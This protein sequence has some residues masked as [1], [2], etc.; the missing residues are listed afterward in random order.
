MLAKRGFQVKVFERRPDVRKAK[1][2][3]VAG[4][5]DA[6]HGQLTDSSKRSINLALSHRGLCGLDKAGLKERVLEWCIPMKG[7]VLHDNSGNIVLQP[8]DANHQAIYS[9]SRNDLNWLLIEEAEKYPNVEFLF[10]YKFIRVD[11]DGM[12]LFQRINADGSSLGPSG[13][14]EVR[15]SV[16]LGADGAF[17][18]V[19]K[20]LARLTRQSTSMEYIKHGYK[21]LHIP[22]TDSGDFAMESEGLHIWPRRE[23]MMIGLPNPDKSFTCTLFA[24]FEG[25]GGFDSL[26][27]REQVEAYFKKYFADAIPLMPN[28]LD[29]FFNNPTSALL[30]LKCSPWNFKDKVAVIGDAAHAIVPFYGQGMNAC[31]EDCVIMDELLETY[32]NDW[33]KVLPAFSATRAPSTNGLAELSLDNYV[34][35]RERTASRLIRAKRAVERAIHTI[36]PSFVPLYTMVA[37]T[38]TP[39]HQAIEKARKQDK[40]LNWVLASSAISV[41]AGASYGLMRYFGYK[42][43]NVNFS[44]SLKK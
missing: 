43:V 11:R 44:V 39:Y 7:R 18:A 35:M 38:R 34:E 3:A 14:L 9:V 23:F 2:A 15:S 13:E 12:V 37:F 33:A 21:E 26:R 16:C 20:C 5:T 36:I 28:Y 24:P 10:N 31:F 41:V 1:A 32:N 30:T 19:R 27:T 29:D 42:G 4:V 8:Y 17:S 6:L 22:P 25:E 40:M